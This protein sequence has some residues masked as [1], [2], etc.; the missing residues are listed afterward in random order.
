MLAVTA[1]P[2]K[3]RILKLPQTAGPSLILPVDSVTPETHE[4]LD[5]YLPDS[6]TPA[7]CVLLVH[8]LYPEQPE[9]SPRFSSFYP[10]YASHLARRGLVAAV[11]DHDLTRGFFYHE[12]LATV[13]NAMEQLRARPETDGDAVGMWFFS[14]GGPL[15]Y[16]FLVDPQPWLRAVQLTYPALPG[17]DTPGWPTPEA[18]IAGIASV[19]TRLTLV[20]NEIPDYVADQRNFVVL[21]AD[22]GVP[23]DVHTVAG[24]GHGFDALAD[25]PRT[26]EVVARNL[27]WMAES[28]NHPA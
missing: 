17:P 4:G 6:G 21:A 23:L 28:L 5:L 11:V 15:S 24:V 3:N 27:D 13:G 12:A 26:R 20:E 18:A 16:P 22:H 1:D 7:P 14:G 25:E 10:A 19:P 2:K 8:G 9:V